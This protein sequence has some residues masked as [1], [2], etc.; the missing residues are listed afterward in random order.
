MSAGLGDSR[1]IRADRAILEELAPLVEIREA[2]VRRDDAALW[3]GY[4]N[5]RN[6]RA[7]LDWVANL[8][9]GRVVEGPDDRGVVHETLV[10]MPL[11]LPSE[12]AWKCS[13]QAW[14]VDEVQLQ[15]RF[16]DWLPT[17]HSIVLNNCLTPQAAIGR[18]SPIFQRDVLTSLAE[19]RAVDAGE[20][21]GKPRHPSIPQLFFILASIR[22]CREEPDVPEFANPAELHLREAIAAQMAF[23]VGAGLEFNAV[24][25]PMRFVQAIQSGFSLW[26]DR[27]LGEGCVSSWDLVLV[28]DD[29]A[30]I[31]FRD[32]D[33]RTIATFPVRLH[34]LE[35][36]G[37]DLI[38][39]ALQKTLGNS[40]RP[41]AL[42]SVA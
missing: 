15:Q 38:A 9:G 32:A 11:V 31:D 4:S 8:V 33:E 6:Q 13:T 39:A 37:L 3:R 16:R 14:V 36:D 12:A 18:W 5:A 22:R 26:L 30:S 21:E 40:R 29:A 35:P 7:Y 41:A 25:P 10:A 17:G 42:R 27:V 2:V 34:Q 24:L 20:P 1:W 23:R 19:Q 28:G